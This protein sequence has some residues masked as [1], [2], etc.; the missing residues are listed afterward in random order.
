VLEY[1]AQVYD[2]TLRQ[3][4][5][6]DPTRPASLVRLD[7]TN[8]GEVMTLAQSDY[9]TSIEVGEC[10]LTGHYGNPPA[11]DECPEGRLFL[12]QDRRRFT[13][14]PRESCPRFMEIGRNS[15]R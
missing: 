3:F 4:P 12:G 13:D 1:V 6:L 5:G 14:L 9:R 8:A 7:H 15:V 2:V 10:I 11:A